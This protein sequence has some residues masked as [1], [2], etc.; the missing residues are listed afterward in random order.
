MMAIESM[1][2]KQTIALLPDNVRE[3]LNRCTAT[4]LVPDPLRAEPKRSW[5]FRVPQGRANANPHEASA[6]ACSV[7]CGPEFQIKF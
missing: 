1:T 4:D 6:S 3:E 5:P 2:M 7:L